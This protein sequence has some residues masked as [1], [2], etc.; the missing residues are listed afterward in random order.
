[1]LR[2]RCGSTV[3]L[4]RSVEIPENPARKREDLVCPSVGAESLVENPQ[5]A[6]GGKADWSLGDPRRRCPGGIIGVCEKCEW[7]P[8]VR[9]CGSSERL[10]CPL[11]HL[12]Q[13]R[14]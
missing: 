6:I 5:P 7:T 9:V 1:G 11:E 10:A 2:H 3:S 13:M 4:P 8:G 12:C 14:T